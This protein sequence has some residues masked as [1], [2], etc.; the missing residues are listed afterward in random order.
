M[1]TYGHL[2]PGQNA[3]AVTNLQPL[4]YKSAAMVLQ[5]AREL[6]GL[7]A[8]GCNEVSNTGAAANE[9]AS[10]RKCSV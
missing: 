2:L 6:E 10:P 3:D 7:G 1:D 8:N 5:S 9:G 4:L